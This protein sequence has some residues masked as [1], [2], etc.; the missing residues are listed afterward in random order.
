MLKVSILGF[1]NIAHALIADGNISKV[2]FFV[3][4]ESFKKNDENVSIINVLDEKIVSTGSITPHV[5]TAETLLNSDVILFCLPSNLREFYL[6]KF[7]DL[8][9]PSAILGAIPGISG[10]NEEVENIL[11]ENR[12]IFSL[13]RVPYISRI[14]ERGKS[15]QS[16][17]KEE[18][19]VACNFDRK[20]CSEVLNTL[21]NM[22]I[23]FLE[24]FDHVNLS[25][26]NPLLHTSRL[27]SYLL[28]KKPPFEIS[29]KEKFYEDW[30]DFASKTLIEMDKE[31]MLLVN[32]LG[33][34]GVRNILEHYDVNS[35]NELT[36]K[37]KSIQSFKAID[38]P[39]I[40][41]KDLTYIVDFN[42]RYF[43][44]DFDHGL[45]YL[46]NKAKLNH[47]EI[48][49]INE[50]LDFYNNVIKT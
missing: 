49:K 14:I 5:S 44:E 40:K 12:K 20:F 9:N 19:F 17:K 25:N 16:Y 33:L 8:F 3:I 15:V 34:N 31:F 32:K 4:S 6:N 26:S 42:S 38:F 46:S 27:Y 29:K 21:F 1:G 45:T 10:F 18:I 11:G 24:N 13:Q 23:S 39:N 50:V 2:N 22:K 28:D 47:I 37:I 7:K 35:V 48:P 36:Q 41:Q 43:S 30:N